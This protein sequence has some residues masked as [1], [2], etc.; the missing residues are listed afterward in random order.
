MGIFSALVSTIKNVDLQI[1]TF[2]VAPTQWK[3]IPSSLYNSLGFYFS[4]PTDKNPKDINRDGSTLLYRKQAADWIGLQVLGSQS[5]LCI[6]DSRWN[7]SKGSRVILF[8]GTS[9]TTYRPKISE[10]HS[11]ISIKAS[12]RD[13]KPNVNVSDFKAVIKAYG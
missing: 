11:V 7:I 10:T 2:A 4:H 6:H 1:D 13:S 8:F 5:A 12:A 3:E 9:G